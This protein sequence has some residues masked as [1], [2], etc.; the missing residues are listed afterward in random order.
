MEQATHDGALLRRLRKEAR[1]AGIPLELRQLVR[2]IDP[3]A[4]TSATAL[5]E[6]ATRLCREQRATIDA[7]KRHGAGK[8]RPEDP[9]LESVEETLEP[10]YKLAHGMAAFPHCTRTDA[11][12]ARI[13]YDVSCLATH[14]TLVRLALIRAANLSSR[15]QFDDSWKVL[16]EAARLSRQVGELPLVL[17]KIGQVICDLRIIHVTRDLLQQNRGLSNLDGVARV[18]AALGPPPNYRAAVR[19]EVCFAVAMARRRPAVVLGDSYDRAEPGWM[20]KQSESGVPVKEIQRS[21]E[22]SLLKHLVPLVKELSDD[23]AKFRETKKAIKNY[24][25]AVASDPMKRMLEHFAIVSVESAS[26][27]VRDLSMRRMLL[28]LVACLRHYNEHDT[29]PESIPNL[30]DTSIDPFSGKPFKM[31]TSAHSLRLYSVGPNGRDDGGIS[32]QEAYRAGSRSF[33]YPFEF[34]LK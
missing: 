6:E 22:T 24:Y 31:I 29:W 32:Q 28:I 17:A 11:S 30:G 9:P 14:D 33:D 34:E 18:V 4:G 20:R 12:Y 21:V 27:L 2:V 1:E 23:L 5:C 16:E 8:A 13:D 25:S 3:Q 15:G 10:L 26:S 7:L 19:Q